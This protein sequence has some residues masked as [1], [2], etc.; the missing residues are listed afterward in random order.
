MTYT[1]D[2]NSNSEHRLIR[3]NPGEG[4]WPLTEPCPERETFNRFIE[5]ARARRK[6][7]ARLPIADASTPRP[8]G[9]NP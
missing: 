6:A 4:T 7:L 3:H 1:P 2:K 5:F 8:E 9:T